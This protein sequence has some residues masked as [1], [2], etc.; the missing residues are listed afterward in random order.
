MSEISAINK[1]V[2]IP[3][4]SVQQQDSVKNSPPDTADNSASAAS[5]VLGTYVDVS[6]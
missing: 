2:V 3:P 4:V 5:D 1:D 6:G